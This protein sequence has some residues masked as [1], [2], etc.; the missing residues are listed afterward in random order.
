MR[1]D[2]INRKFQDQDRD[3][4]H[5]VDMKIRSV[6]KSVSFWAW[7]QEKPLRGV[8]LF[9]FA[10]WIAVGIYVVVDIRETIKNRAGLVLKETEDEGTDN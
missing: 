1:D 5:Y 6:K 8:L 3:L 10:V 9:D 2:E 4:K 7:M